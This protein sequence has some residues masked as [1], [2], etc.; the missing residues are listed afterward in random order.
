VRAATLSAWLRALS[1]ALW[2]AGLCTTLPAQAHKPSDS[3]L[4]LTVEGAVV[5]GQW[6][7]ALR[8]LDFALGLDADGDGQITWGELRAR[9]AEITAYALARLRVDADGAP[10]TL[11]AGRQ[12]VDEHTDGSYS[13]LE[14]TARCPQAPRSLVL[15]YTLFSDLDP[16][17]RGLLRLAHGRQTRT[18]VLGPQAATQVF[19]LQTISRL[20]QFLD[21]GREG[22][23][24]IWVGH[25]HILFL[26]SLLL[27]AVLLWDGAVWRPADRFRQASMDVLRIV[28][29]FTVA[30]SITLSLAT[31]GLVTPPSRWVESAIALSV[32]LAA[33]NNVWPLFHGRRWM[34]AFCFGLI[35]GFGFASVLQD[36]GLPREALVLA[37]VGFNLGVEAGQLAIVAGFLPLA[38]A[39]RR[40]V[41]YR[42]GV[43]MSGSLLI[44]LVA[45]IWLAERIFNFK[46]LPV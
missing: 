6:D 32:V 20:R 19:D 22:V 28:T 27:P 25:D 2:L 1:L 17:H 15:N 41:F 37:L 46:V 38:F 23:G 29:A 43:L 8:D 40:T 21:Y 35:H 4:A 18:A 31:F 24:H 10:C 26:L 9:H 33:L 14:F 39:A 5:A 3:Y 12:L 45:G 7:I 42:Q 13:V 44:A 30:H 36:L 16:Q 34:V 11:L